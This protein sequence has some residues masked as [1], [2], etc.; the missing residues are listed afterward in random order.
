MLD[1]K[2]G[3]RTPA[4][5]ATVGMWLFLAALTM[6][7]GATMVGYLII[8]TRAGGAA[9]MGT[10]RFPPLLW[11][12]TAV[13][14]T[15]SLTIHL[16]V[17]AARRER[18]LDLRRWMA[19]TCVLAALFCCVQVPAL[20]SLWSQHEAARSHSMY[21][22][23]LIVILIIV[24][25]LHVLGGIIALGIATRHAFQGRYDHEHYNGVKHASMYWHFLDVVWLVMFLGM[26]F[27]G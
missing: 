7:F 23:G 22:Y 6:L 17:S 8:R 24:H 12:S 21:L 26:F 5:T 10:L 14:L 19:A 18:Q 25:A 4:Y 27:A 9:A 11:L 3:H 1:A 20:A 15:G 16:A 2:P 13:I